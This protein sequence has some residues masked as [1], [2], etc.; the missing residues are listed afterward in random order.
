MSEPSRRSMPG[1]VRTRGVIETVVSPSVAGYLIDTYGPPTMFTLIMGAHLALLMYTLWR[2]LVRP[3]STEKRPYRYMP[4][5]TLYIAHLIRR[6]RKPAAK[7]DGGNA[8]G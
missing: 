3:A 4:R 2:S 8:G 7:T 1:I 6:R 5:T